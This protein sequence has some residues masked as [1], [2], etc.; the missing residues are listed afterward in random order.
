MSPDDDGT[1]GSPATAGAISPA[2]RMAGDR[3]AHMVGALALL[4]FLLL[5][6]TAGAAL[7]TNAVDDWAA[8]SA[9]ALATQHRWVVRPG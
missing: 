7:H 8:R 6:A 3:P 9:H 1:V 5:A 2:A 4:M